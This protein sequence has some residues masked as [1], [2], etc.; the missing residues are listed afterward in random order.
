MVRKAMYW[1]PIAAVVGVFIPLPG[2]TEIINLIPD[3]LSRLSAALPG[4]LAA[5]IAMAAITLG[6]IYW[7]LERVFEE[8][9]YTDK[10]GEGK[11]GWT[12]PTWFNRD[13]AVR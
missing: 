10:S 5:A 6:A 4:S 12:I 7:A 8:A 3:A 2:K 1:V 11:D 9:E 13:A